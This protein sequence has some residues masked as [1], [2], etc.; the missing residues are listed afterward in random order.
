MVLK[1]SNLQGNLQGQKGS[2]WIIFIYLG[3]YLKKKVH[4]MTNVV[5]K[6]IYTKS[7]MSLQF[8]LLP[9]ITFIGQIKVS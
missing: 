2:M 7:Y 6:Y 5:M 8:T 9:L 4:A 1:L 3:Y